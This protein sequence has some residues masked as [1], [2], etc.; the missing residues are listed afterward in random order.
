VNSW[1]R[2]CGLLLEG[3][4][5]PLIATV[6]LGSVGY[7]TSPVQLGVFRGLHDSRSMFVVSVKNFV[8]EIVIDG[9]YQSV[10]MAAFETSSG[11]SRLELQP[12]GS[13]A[14]FIRAGETVDIYFTLELS[15]DELRSIFKA[16][17]DYEVKIHTV[18]SYDFP[19]MVKCFYIPHDS[20]TI[21]DYF[22]LSSGGYTL[23][24]NFNRI[25]DL[26]LHF[27]EEG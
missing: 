8:D 14:V 11:D 13:Y 12:D 2:K 23:E 20:W 16:G 25:T 3:E 1:F 18:S 10:I 4:F 9:K 17:V 7:G 19:K 24:L 15:K 6:I 26:E 27:V 5:H 22:K 21:Y